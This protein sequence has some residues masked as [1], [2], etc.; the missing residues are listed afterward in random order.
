MNMLEIKKHPNLL[1]IT[2]FCLKNQAQQFINKTALIISDAPG[3]EQIFS[4]AELYE[5]VSKLTM[6][7]GSLHLAKGTIVAIQASDTLD[8]ILLFLAAIAANLVPVPLLLSL[9]NDEVNYILHDANVAVFFQLGREQ[10]SNVTLPKGCRIMQ[11][12]E[13]S[14]LKNFPFQ[15]MHPHTN[16]KDP[17]Y[18]F[19]T[20]GS[21]G[22]PKGV[23]H[24]QAAIL[25]RKPSITYWLNL[26]ES[27]IVMQTDNLCW[28]YSM[29]TGLLDPLQV[30]ATAVIFN[31][32]NRSSIAEDKINGETWLQII[33][34]YGITVMVSTPDIYNTILNCDKLTYYSIPTLRVAGS[35]GAPLPQVTQERWQAAFQF[36]IYTALG[37]SEI[38]TFISTGPSIPL[39]N[40]TLGKIQPGR[41]VTILPLDEGFNTIAT[42]TIG[43]LAVHR[44]ELGFML[45]YI[46]QK[47][48][49]QYRRKWFLT[50]DLVSMDPDGYISYYGRADMIL[51][52]S[53]GFRVS[54][55]EI[56]NVLKLHPEVIDAACASISNIDN[57]DILVA[58]IVANNPSDDLAK[59]ILQHTATHLSDYKIPQHIYFVSQLPYN[60]RGKLMRDKLNMKH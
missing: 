47:N 46:G 34:H 36:P 58:Y 48:K 14:K 23:L 27:D 11:S 31:P 7:L 49:S 22:T 25:G 52:V 28:T 38:S 4:Y 37:M 24:A 55:V 33:Q 41:K 20:S 40:N 1:N 13:Y 43:M 50:Q 3:K 60:S 57:I 12:R 53:G 19:Y 44:D 18:I 26:H 15:E 21:S 29:N 9:S 56:E 39:R 16:F 2:E 51:K 8:L 30:G 5:L 35:A 42:N 17:A 6:G 10:N 32:S 54:P 59:N 45:G